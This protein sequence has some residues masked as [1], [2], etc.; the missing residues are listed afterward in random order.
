MSAPLKAGGLFVSSTIRQYSRAMPPA[1][2]VI[3]TLVGLTSAATLAAQPT[4]DPNQDP[5]P[6][7]LEQFRRAVSRVLEETGVPGAGIALV[8]ANGI[9]WAGGVGFADRD[10]KTPVT[11]DTHFRAGSI[12]KTFIAMAVVQLSE[13]DVVDLEAPLKTVAPDVAFEN[14][15]EDTH[16]VR[17]ID[18]LQ[19]AAGFD[20]MH[21]KEMYNVADAPDLPLA[22]VLALSPGS[23]RS[24][25]PPGTRM[26]Y[27]NP[28]YGVAGYLIEHLSGQPYEDYIEKEIFEPLGMST[29]S[30]RL[31][32]EDEPLLARGYGA[33]TGP[34]V[35]FTPIYLRP[36]GNLHTSP[37]ELGIFVQM[38]LGWGELGDAFV[39]DP[40][41][42][43][44]MERSRT[45]LA[46][47]AGLR[48]G[49]GSGIAHMLSFPYPMLGHGGG[50]DGFL[51]SYAY[52]PARDVG[53]VVLLNSTASPAAISRI[54]SLAV[55]YL[56][57]GVEPPAKPRANVPD[58]T[59]R[60]H[61]GYYHE[62]TSRNQLSA[63]L[64]W[65]T[66]GRTIRLEGSTLYADPVFGSPRALVP[67]SDTLFRLG[68]EVDAT[69]VFTVDAGGNAVFTGGMGLYAERVPRWIVEIVRWPV[70][71]S[72]LVMLTPVVAL[73]GWLAYARRARPR[74]FWGLKALL[75]LVPLASVAP[76][77]A[78]WAIHMR[79][80][81]TLNWATALAF[82]GTIALP[83]LGVAVLANTWG[84][85]RRGAGRWLVGYSGLV[86]VAALIVSGYL[87]YWGTLGLRLWTY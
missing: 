69:R 65:L 6:E 59:L 25:W 47:Q 3:L 20:D 19:H 67:V 62:A 42:L 45:T 31:R 33:R 16:P 40:E 48:N 49:Y 12:S 53:F 80:W 70:L 2:L 23:R 18:V 55:R 43:S 78:L 30:F 72:A 38:L 22:D 37:R 24:R 27:S 1:R 7:T 84:A 63:F 58:D 76:V 44:N 29:S 74:G 36:A 71:M 86:A 32:P 73:L 9:E 21:F 10:L 60:R 77:A 81:G 28:G 64:E 34:P 39:I 4:P 14:P 11:A 51:S 83:V 26:S 17:V 79:Q 66:A 75:V 5:T 68:E 87:G 15:W 41:Y 46:S 57:R 54:S 52:S 85:R 8:G 82:V 61:E 56:K 13:D 35:P 50:I